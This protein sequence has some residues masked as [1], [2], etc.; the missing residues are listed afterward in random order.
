VC[1]K[2]ELYNQL[3]VLCISLYKCEDEAILKQILSSILRFS[4]RHISIYFDCGYLDLLM[5]LL[6]NVSGEITEGL[7]VKSSETF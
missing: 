6:R 2:E 3:S 1:S 7:V 5:R 4:P